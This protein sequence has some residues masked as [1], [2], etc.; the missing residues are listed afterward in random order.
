[1]KDIKIKTPLMKIQYWISWIGFIIFGFIAG[2]I[3]TIFLANYGKRTSNDVDNKKD[4]LNKTWQKF[5]FIFGSITGDIFFIMLLIDI[6]Q[7]QF[8]GKPL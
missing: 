4:V 8:T 2:W 5:V 3:I 6:I 1:M 7:M